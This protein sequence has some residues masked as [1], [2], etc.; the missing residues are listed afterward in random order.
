VRAR[1]K[2]NEML[3]VKNEKVI[4]LILVWLQTLH[5]TCS[6]VMSLVEK[7]EEDRR[8]MQLVGFSDHH[9][10]SKS[11]VTLDKN[12]LSCLGGQA[13]QMEKSRVI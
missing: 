2:I 11:T 13:N 9:P 5:D 8:A 6:T 4:S 10:S 12:C 3:N 1:I 7:D